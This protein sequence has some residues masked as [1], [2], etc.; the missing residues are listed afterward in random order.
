[1]SIGRS[2]FVSARL[3]ASYLGL[4]F[5]LVIAGLSP[6]QSQ[7]TAEM[8]GVRDDIGKLL[9]TVSKGDDQQILVADLAQSG[10]GYTATIGKVPN[11]RYFKINDQGHVAVSLLNFGF[12]YTL[13]GG[14]KAQIKFE[15][16][17]VIIA[18]ADGDYTKD[19]LPTG[20]AADIVERDLNADGK[21]TLKAGTN[22]FGTVD[23]GDSGNQQLHMVVSQLGLT[24][25][26]VRV[27]GE[28][29]VAIAKLIF[30]GNMLAAHDSKDLENMRL[31]AVLPDAKPPAAKGIVQ[32]KKPTFILTTEQ[33]DGLVPNVVAK[34]LADIEVKAEGLD[35]I[36]ECEMVI[37]PPAPSATD[38]VVLMS[39]GIITKPKIIDFSG[40]IKGPMPDLSTLP[41]PK[42]PALKAKLTDVKVVGGWHLDGKN[43][44]NIKD[45]DFSVG[46]LGKAA[47]GTKPV[48]LL[49]MMVASAKN[50]GANDRIKFI[51]RMDGD[52][53]VPDLI[54][55]DYGVAALKQP[56][57]TEILAT[58][59]TLSATMTLRGEE[60]TAVFYDTLEKNGKLTFN[61]ALGH[62]KFEIGN[63][64]NAAKGTIAGDLRGSDGVM[65]V[66]I[67][68][69]VITSVSKLNEPI[70]EG[71]LPPE[72]L[73]LMGGVEHARFPLHLK[74]GLNLMARI[75]VKGSSA[76]STVWKDL[77]KKGEDEILLYGSIDRKILSS[78][79]KPAEELMENVDL[80]AQLPALK[81]SLVPPRTE[82][83]PVKLHLFGKDKKVH[84]QAVSDVIVDLEEVKLD[85]QGTIDLSGNRKE[86]AELT[87][88]AE[89][90]KPWNKPFGISE[91]DLTGLKLVAT[92]GES[93]LGGG[94]N[95]TKA[96]A[97]AGI[98]DTLLGVEPLMV[99]DAKAKFFNKVGVDLAIS[100]WTEGKA[101][102]FKLKQV[103]FRLRG[104]HKLKD[105]PYTNKLPNNPIVKQVLDFSAKDPELVV[106][107][108]KKLLS[109]RVDLDIEKQKFDLSFFQAPDLKW[110][111]MLGFG[112]LDVSGQVDKVGGPSLAL[113]F[114]LAE[115]L[116]KAKLGPIKELIE[117]MPDI[118]FKGM[119]FA[120]SEG[121]FNVAMG[122]LPAPAQEILQVIYGKF[123]QGPKGPELRLIDGMNLLA[124]IDGKKFTAKKPL[125]MLGLKGDLAIQGS[126]GGIFGDGTPSIV[127]AAALPEW[128]FPSALTRVTKKAFLQLDS[129]E[130]SFFIKIIPGAA[131]VGIGLDF[132]MKFDG[133]QLDL[134]GAYEIEVTDDDVGVY[135][136]GDLKG[137]WQKPFRIPALWIRNPV[138]KC[139]IE[140][141]V[142]VGAKCGFS[143]FT[144]IAGHEVGLGANV[145][146]DYE[147]EWVQVDALAMKGSLNQLALS[148]LAELANEAYAMEQG[149]WHPDKKYLT[150]ITIG[151][152]ENVEL[153]DVKFEFVTPGAADPDLGFDGDGF[154][155]TGTL[156][157]FGSNLGKVN[158]WVNLDGAKVYGKVRGFNYKGFKFDGAKIDISLNTKESPA[159]GVLFGGHFLGDKAEV[160]IDM[161]IAKDRFGGFADVKAFNAFEAH[162]K[163]WH[164]IAA[165]N[166][167]VAANQRWAMAP[168]GPLA[169]ATGDF[170]LSAD[171]AGSDAV[172]SVAPP[173]TPAKKP[174]HK[175]NW[176]I[177]GASPPK[178]TTSDSSLDTSMGGY[179]TNVDSGLVAALNPVTG[180][181]E[182]LLVL[183][184]KKATADKAQLW[185][186][187]LNGSL[188]NEKNGK[189]L[190]M[191]SGGKLSFA[192]LKVSQTNVH[193]FNV[194]GKFK[195][196]VKNVASNFVKVVEK[197]VN[198]FMHMSVADHEKNIKRSIAVAEAFEKKYAVAIEDYAKSINY[199]KLAK[200][201]YANQKAAAEKH[202]K[203]IEAAE[204]KLKATFKEVVKESA[205]EADKLELAAKKK[206]KETITAFE[207]DFAAAVDTEI[208]SKIEPEI[209]K[210]LQNQLAVYGVDI[211]KKEEIYLEG[212]AKQ[213]E[214]VKANFA[215][216][217]KPFEALL[218]KA[219]AAHKTAQALEDKLQKQHDA[220]KTKYHFAALS[221][222]KTFDHAF[223]PRLRQ[224]PLFQRASFGAQA[225]RK[226]K[227]GRNFRPLL[228][229]IGFL[230]D[231]R[232]GIK[233]TKKHL[234]HDESKK[235]LHLKL[236][237]VTVSPPAAG[238]GVFG[239]VPG[240]V[241]P[242]S[243]G[244][245]KLPNLPGPGSV[246]QEASK[247]YDKV[248]VQLAKAVKDTAKLKSIVDT[249]TGRI[250]KIDAAIKQMDTKY[251]VKNAKTLAAVKK[252]LNEAE[253]DVKKID[254]ALKDIKAGK[255]PKSYR[256]ALHKSDIQ[257]DY[258]K[259]SKSGVGIIQFTYDVFGKRKKLKSIKWDFKNP[260][261]SVNHLVAE[262]S[263]AKSY[264]KLL[265]KASARKYTVDVKS[266]PINQYRDIHKQ[267]KT[268]KKI[269]IPKATAKLV[270]DSHLN[271]T[272]NSHIVLVSEDGKYLTARGTGAV[273]AS[274]KI[275]LE[276][277]KLLVLDYK[278]KR[279]KGGPKYGSND[280]FMQFLNYNGRY[281]QATDKE[282]TGLLYKYAKYQQK[283]GSYQMRRNSSSSYI[284]ISRPMIPK[285]W[286]YLGDTAYRGLNP[287]PGTGVIFKKN[288]A[289]F[290]KPSSFTSLWSTK[291]TAAKQDV[292]I[293]TAASCPSGT[294]KMGD[295]GFR[296]W[297]PSRQGGDH[298]IID[299]FRC[300]NTKYVTRH[301][302][303][304]DAAFYI[305]R[306][307]DKPKVKSGIVINVNTATASPLA[308]GHKLWMMRANGGHKGPSKWGWKTEPFLNEKFFD[309][310][311]YWA[312][313][314]QVRGRKGGPEK[315][316]QFLFYKS[317][318]PKF[319]GPVKIGD[320]VYIANRGTGEYLRLNGSDVMA[321]AD[322]HKASKFTIFQVK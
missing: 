32:V 29:S 49:A 293:A 274:A 205:T 149:T 213:I 203:N 6:S 314:K 60:T 209:K 18:S 248:K 36:C 71:Q 153:K 130:P 175:L 251:G 239:S 77:F 122:E 117:K 271:L 255:L 256:V 23:A 47:V 42:L 2:I 15:K 97:Q 161:G 68:P 179:L 112:G 168:G 321:D 238:A 222:P 20:L 317:D 11:S 27:S 244:Q 275:P 249:L 185:Q 160:D 250:K 48:D 54:G 306:N 229:N 224:N 91:I 125:S 176:L 107:L 210:A 300:L 118:A 311:S 312:Q 154:I 262:I 127:L 80:W 214:D 38:K 84:A 184:E 198:K 173:P 164:D 219:T 287:F 278:G 108:K 291:N 55:T 192:A 53:T 172:L 152:T 16:G 58:R 43:L 120:F 204:K 64:I 86:G 242:K 218:T 133:S 40:V 44:K 66:G 206:L 190:T 316:R 208:K 74:D 183:Q 155:A 156:N 223:V 30:S 259:I 83:T 113:A 75:D 65:I 1:M 63:Y 51:V 289:A 277:S 109:F 169:I 258:K 313:K 67:K 282:D 261:A 174:D 141:G 188:M 212:I 110:N 150:P 103:G 137:V 22:V 102:N 93:T 263:D 10:K 295:V 319:Q 142:G 322:V 294:A 233:N 14:I 8:K 131:E 76:L 100:I 241:T 181:G 299:S 235:P 114:E 136:V 226:L 217:R 196:D 72:V 31:V 85:L 167:H 245:E 228:Q 247:L 305:W 12:N 195:E 144:A 90:V 237:H 140:A 87:L 143:G 73:D 302:N 46:L 34:V 276:S 194:E 253:K 236:P 288:G 134:G 225:Q 200:Q 165:K 318:N 115:K 227:Q 286:V 26:S 197:G 41:I 283:W 82:M 231:V 151:K 252:H 148:D 215:T 69:T 95:F 37:N 189:Y 265:K 254:K 166:K 290:K 124:T 132:A 106:G 230:D 315:D 13:P 135:L 94:K 61:L 157:A 62:K 284:S 281:V 81:D 186:I 78:K 279:L 191:G 25:N 119:A 285:G 105:L 57:L 207:K 79:G 116:G 307:V 296:H 139:G 308:F 33:G 177:A 220:L 309:D 272:Y 202:L 182:P 52:I 98:G 111:M 162:L 310:F 301:K 35:Y 170:V 96:K 292:V 266:N 260:T 187:N 17:L 163:I 298:E 129:I 121:G 216:Q 243:L 234:K 50:Q 99:L 269:Q 267:I 21:F 4:V 180:E 193:E 280:S 101:Q 123:P 171:P 70:L 264:A 221:I 9:G 5:L 56:A 3:S 158:M 24:S 89:S 7:E 88:T 257:T 39:R 59:H 126:M 211:L 146:V 320:S 303:W 297:G 246:K 92:L 159:F 232:K 240:R 28:F 147:G 273:D 128:K 178:A 270:A 138:V 201:A 304:W 45:S 268:S 145:K 104:D 19:V 199:K